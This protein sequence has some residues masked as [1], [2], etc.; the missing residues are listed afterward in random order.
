MGNL[1]AYFLIPVVGAAVLLT[2]CE[3]SEQKRAAV[4]PPMRAQAPTIQQVEKQSA[5]TAPTPKIE[6]KIVPK[7]DP[8]EVLIGRVRREYQEG[9][10]NYNAGHLEAAKENFD[11]AFNILLQGP[12]E[13]KS[14]ERLEQEFDRLVE[15]V[16]N[17]ELIALKEGDGFTEQ[18]S[19]P[20]PIDEANEVTFPIDPNIRAKAEEEL[21]TTQSDLPL[22]LNDSVASYISYFSNRGRRSLE[23]GYI[24]SGRYRDMIL[25]IL[26]E[27]GVPQDLIYLA[28]AE[29]GFHPI[30]LSR[31]G[32][33]GMWQFMASRGVGY[34]LKRNWWIDDRQDP[35]KAT[36]AAA[37]HLKD[38]YAQF[39][40]WYLAMAAYNSGPGNVQKAVQRTGYADFWELYRRGVLPGETRNYVPIILAITIM[41]KNP[42]QYGLDRVRWDKPL[43]YET[44]EVDYPVDLRLVAECV[45]ASLST[46]QELNP[47]LIRLTTPK[48]Q[49]FALHVPVGTTEIYQSAIA[50]IPVDKRVSWHYHKLNPGDTLAGVAK[51]YR[52]TV[53]AIVEANNLEGEEVGQ[54]AKLIIPVSSSRRGTE[55]AYSKRATRYTVRRGDTVTSIAD[56]F[57]VPAEQVRKWNRI[58]GNS[59]KAGRSL[60]IHRPVAGGSR[61]PVSEAQEDN[62]EREVAPCTKWARKGTGRNAKRV[63]VARA[64]VRK[65]SNPKTESGKRAGGSRRES[66]TVRHKVKKGETLSSIASAYNTTVAALQRD[67]HV[68]ASRLKIGAVL[69]IKGGQ[70]Q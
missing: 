61:V 46:L 56:D 45:D 25:R 44:V 59:V 54:R 34:G 18:P 49:K 32:A 58:K 26:K 37:R 65:V 6:E 28:Q 13:V 43:Q 22:T 41:S 40:D 20:A 47:S 9:Q 8:V 29:S 27:E 48:D 16:H 10:A 66:A 36:R 67:N 21:K 14:D 42:A 7:V 30:A 70:A 64:E 57:G 69:V 50:A 15:S 19:E 39:G 52:T 38:L 51:K 53:Q 3:T 31:A 68:A 5:P 33:R 55:I 4:A 24:R 62:S 12:P 11:R 17:L 23:H 60:V 63:C 2:S 1:K 35:E